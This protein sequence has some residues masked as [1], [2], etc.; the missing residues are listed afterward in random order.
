MR[1]KAFND[2][3][4]SMLLNTE[5]IRDVSVEASHLNLLAMVF[6]V[7]RHADERARERC[8]FIKFGRD[9]AE[10]IF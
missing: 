7:A 8:T 5:A 9:G 10:E 1:T 4:A 3:A 6:F 2:I